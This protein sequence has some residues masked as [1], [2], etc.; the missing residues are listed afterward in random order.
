M[1]KIGNEGHGDHQN[2]I[3]KPPQMMETNEK[4]TYAAKETLRLEAFSDGVFAIAITLLILEIHVPEATADETLL[5]AI[6]HEWASFIAFLIGFFTLLVCWINHHYMFSVIHKSNSRLLLVNGFKLLVVSVTPFAT[7]LLAKNIQTTWQPS[8]VSLYCFN[9][10]LMGSAM[11]S[12]WLYAKRKG[13]IQMKS[14]KQ[15]NVA[16]RYYVFASILSTSIWLVSYINVAC[17]LVLFCLMFV[18]YVFPEKMVTWQTAR[19]NGKELSVETNAD[20]R[21]PAHN[22][23]MHKTVQ[24]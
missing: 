12:I 1:L 6:A 22:E 3:L 24:S 15:L 4:K 11:T 20:E 9:F 17:S 23:P 8:A 18:I 5:E 2:I 19:N 21:L 13:F 7:A 10:A 16:T 14:E